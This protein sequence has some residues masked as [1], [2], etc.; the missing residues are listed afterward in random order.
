MLVYHLVIIF[1]SD[2]SLGSA[3]SKPDSH[4]TPGTLRSHETEDINPA[5]HHRARQPSSTY[6]GT[7]AGVKQ[8]Y[9]S[10]MT[11]HSALLAQP[12]SANSISTQIEIAIQ[13]QEMFSQTP[14]NTA[15]YTLG[16]QQPNSADQ[17]PTT[18][19]SQA[20]DSGML[21]IQRA[22]QPP[23]PAPRANSVHPR[24]SEVRLERQVEQPE[25]TADT[26]PLSST[27][28]PESALSNTSNI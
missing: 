4:A 23:I 13:P 2:V 7:L 10:Q 21:N 20:D 8:P 19:A 28:Q 6:P 24:R 11:G 12:D 3:S 14:L 18:E 16:Q 27:E 9:E 5:R 17:P 26:T 22:V 1:P 25:S 15:A